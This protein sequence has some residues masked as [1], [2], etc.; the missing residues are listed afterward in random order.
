MSIQESIDFIKDNPVAGNNYMEYE[1]HSKIL[2]DEVLRLKEVIRNTSHGRRVTKPDIRPLNDVREG[3]TIW[4]KEDNK[5]Y[6]VVDDNYFI[7][8][9]NHY[10]RTVAQ[11]T[12]LIEDGLAFRIPDAMRFGSANYYLLEDG[13][14]MLISLG[15]NWKDGS[16]IHSIY[17]WIPDPVKGKYTRFNITCGGR[18]GGKREYVDF[19]TAHLKT[20]NS[21]SIYTSRYLYKAGQYQKYVNQA[22]PIYRELTGNH[23]FP[24]GG[25]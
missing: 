19:S 12:K 20:E 8:N 2:A 3:S 17:V 18:E 7:I 5:F 4:M 6:S 25:K 11:A 10:Y 9:D 13:E 1:K 22:L 16:Y 24:E 21:S 14:L 15:G 23:T